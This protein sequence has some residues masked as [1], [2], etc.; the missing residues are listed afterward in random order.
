VQPV[1]FKIGADH[2]CERPRLI[3]ASQKQASANASD[4]MGSTL[5]PL[6]EST[7]PNKPT[8]Q[9]T[10]PFSAAIAI[11]TLIKGSTSHY[12]YISEAVTHGLMRVQLDTGIPVIYGVLNCF[13]EEQ[14][15]QR[16][17]VGREE[18][19]HNHGIDWGNAAVELAAKTHRW[20]QGTI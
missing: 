7:T 12:E 6:V 13:T 2:W 17:G 15:L 4:L 16:A 8:R 9:L 3:A 20:A 1:G 10:G 11:G 14:A 5:D 19:G 18:P